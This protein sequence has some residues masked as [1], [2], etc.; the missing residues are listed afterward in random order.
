MKASEALDGMDSF[1]S[2]GSLPPGDRVGELVRAAYEAFRDVDDGACSEV[3][4]VL[5][6]ADPADFGVAVTSV[7]GERFAV[8]DLDTRF[9]LMS[10]SK[11]FVLAL[12]CEAL[13]SDI[14]RDRVGVNSTGRPFNSVA[15][16]EHAPGGRTNPMVN[17]G[18]IATTGLVPG[19]DLED[20]WRFIV[21]GLS[22]FAGRT[23]AV[24]E[25]VLESARATNG[26]NRAIA[27]LLHS[28]GALDGDPEAAV[29]LYTRQCSLSVDVTD[30]STMG[31]TLSNGGT[32]PIVGDVIV[33]PLVCH[34]V[35]A[36]M[37][38]AGL[39]DTSGEWLWRVGLPGKSG[40]SGGIVT[41]S[42]GKGALGTYSPPLDSAGNSVRGQLVSEYLARGLGLDVFAAEPV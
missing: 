29:E 8:G 28:L 15:A 9:T 27:R 17:S 13:G 19:G 2:T 5:A 10:L 1:V 16:V 24:D 35:L 31:A 4:P 38:T 40:I 7:R 26:R 18:A 23:L 30:L 32:N 36:V 6:Q 20:R 3:Y 33:Q 22:R 14:V 42:P 39:Y 21:D 34:D 37:A 12:V 25:A 11:P 41:V